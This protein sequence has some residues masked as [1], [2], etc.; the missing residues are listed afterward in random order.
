[1]LLSRALDRRPGGP[2]WVAPMGDEV[3]RLRALLADA[4]LVQE[5]PDRG[6]KLRARLE[7]LQRE[8]AQPRPQP[9][10]PQ[11]PRQEVQK[12]AAAAPAAAPAAPR[13]AF[14]AQ[15]A[16]R[17]GEALYPRGAMLV[18]APVRV[19]ESAAA[20]KQRERVL[21]DL[22]ESNG[23]SALETLPEAAPSPQL[24]AQLYP[25]QLAGLRWLLARERLTGEEKDRPKPLG[26]HK[27]VRGG[28]LAD[29]MG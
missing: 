9:Q 17:E 24:R 28:I 10:Q 8:A 25:H 27:S 4:K 1:M 2:T 16:A 19:F 26:A 15:G 14:T 5:L 13:V 23:R 12:A 11:A 20:E 18:S 6:A 22:L 21:A 3:A 7:A 29:D